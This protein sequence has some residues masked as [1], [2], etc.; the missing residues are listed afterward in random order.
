MF[1]KKDKQTIYFHNYNQ[2]NKNKIKKFVQNKFSISN[3][4]SFVSEN[5]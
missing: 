3:F 5:Q 4:N 2:K 1:R